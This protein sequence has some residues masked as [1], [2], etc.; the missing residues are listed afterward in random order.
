MEALEKKLGITERAI[1]IRI[2]KMRKERLVTREVGAYLL[3]ADQDIDLSKYL[4]EE[5]LGK[6][7]EA[8][9]QQIAVTPF[10]TKTRGRE[11]TTPSLRK[12]VVIAIGRGLKIINPNLP[13]KL[14]KEAQ[15]MAG[16]YPV[17]YIFENSTRHLIITVLE[18]EYGADWWDTCVSSTI[19]QKVSGRMK[20]ETPWH[21][22]RGA[23]EIFYTD[24]G[25]LGSIIESNWESFEHI[26]PDIPWAKTR[27][28]EYEKLRNIVNHSN[29]LS[30]RNIK[31]LEMYLL[32]WID[33]VS[34]LG[35]E[36]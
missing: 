27:I 30:S 25:D 15:T 35:E 22:K 32:D 14:I 33:Q 9:L 26:F 2:E 31:R 11:S 34:Q 3:A 5:E 8:R 17:I 6:V 20:S 10:S 16:V 36:T 1:Y 18:D 12:Q 4:S 7:R 24:L 19:R 13:E 23:Q 21:G 29:P 28:G